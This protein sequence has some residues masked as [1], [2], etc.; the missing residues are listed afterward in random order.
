MKTSSII[1][2]SLCMFRLVPLLAAALAVPQGLQASTEYA[3]GSFTWDNG[4][5]AKWSNLPSGPY[6]TVWTSG[7][8]AVLEGTAGTVTVSSATTHSLTFNTT[9]YILSGASTLTLNGTTP[10]I[11]MPSGIAAATIG[12]NTATVLAGSAGLTKAGYG[13]V[14]LNSSAVHTFTG[15]LTINGGGG[16]GN[17][18]GGINVSL[19]NLATPTNLINSS[20]ALTLSGATLTLTGKGSAVSSQ[21]F[22][23]TTVNSG[24]AWVT[25]TQNSATSLTANLGAITRN[26]GGTLRFNNA[27]STTG[28]IATTTNSNESSGILGTWAAV[29]QNTTS[30]QYAA[31]NGS[32][33]IVTYT[34]ATTTAQ[35]ANLSDVSNSGVN[36]AF[37][38]TVTPTL[39]GPITAN[40]L[41]FTGATAGTVTTAGNNITLNGLMCAGSTTLTIGV[42]GGPNGNLVI[43]GNKE[44]VILDNNQALNIY[45]PITDNGGGASSLVFGTGGNGGSA[46]LYGNLNYTGA[47]TVNSGTL[48]L[49]P[50]ASSWTYTTENMTVNGGTLYLRGD[51]FAGGGNF[52]VGNITLNAGGVL[53]G[54]RANMVANTGCTLT[55]NGGRYFED[56]GFAGSWTGPVYLA[57][58]SYL[59]TNG[60]WCQNQAITGVISG[61]GG[62][63]SYSGNYNAVITLNSV[64]IYTGKTIITAGSSNTSGALQLGASGSIDT[65]PLISI[66]AGGIFDVSLKSAGYTWSSN[67]TLVAAGT[68]SPSSIKGASGKTINM[69]SQPI[70]LTYDG[71]HPA[72]TVSQGTLALNAN[73]ITVNGA[74]LLATSTYNVVSQTTG[75]ISV[76]GT[77][78][79]VGGSAIPTG[80]VGYLTT[81]GTSPGY[82]VLNLGTPSLT[83]SSFPSSQTAGVAGTVTVTAKDPLGNPATA[84]IGTVHFTSSDSLAVLPADYTFVPADN[85]THTFNVTLKTAG[86]QSITATDTGT[87]SITSTQSGITVTPAAAA[88]LTVAGFPA[89]KTAG[90]PD[91]V[92]VTAKDAF[93]NT[94]TG[95]TGT[96]HLS[97]S[98]GAASLPSDYTF[99]GGDSGTSVFS[100]TLNT[101][102]PP[103]VSITATDTVTGSITGTQSGITVLPGASAAYLVVSGF[104]ASPTAGVPGSITV[105][106]KSSGGT[107]VTSY[108]GTVHFTSTDGTATLPADYTFVSGDNGT[109]A[110]TGVILKTAAVQSITATDTGTAITGT[111]SSIGVVPD[112]AFSL[113][114]SGYPSP[115]FVGTAGDVTVTAKDA[116]GNVATAYNGTVQ[117]TSSDI[118]ATL[119]PNYSFTGAGGDNGTH[120]FTGGVTFA[121]AGTQ[122]IIATDTIIGS[123]TGTQSG[124]TVNLVP[125]L[126]SWTNASGG[127]W[128]V[129]GNWTNDAGLLLAPVAGGKSNYALSF[130]QAGSYTA[131]NNLGGNYLLNQLTF[132]GSGVTLAG[133]SLKLVSDTGLPAINQNS[134]TAVSIGNDL[135]LDADTTL[136]G[137]GAG[138]VTLTGVVSGTGSLTKN[139]TG[140]L[141]LTGLVANTYQG[142]TFINNGSVSFGNTLNGMLGTGT[143]TM[144][145]GT[146]LQFNG[147]NNVTN[148]FILRGATIINSNGFAANLNGPVALSGTCTA[149][150]GNTGQMVISGIVSDVSGTEIGSLTKIGASP[151]SLVLTAANTYTGTTTINAGQLQ[152]GS[153]GTTGSLAPSG[154]ITNNATLVF[155]RSNTMT[156]G[157]DFPTGISGSGALIQSGTGTLVLSGSNTYSGT[158]NVNSGTLLVNG[159]N[160][161]T[162]AVSVAS[163][164]TLGGSGSIGGNVTYAS[165]ALACFTQGSTLTIG[166]SLTLNDNIVHLVLPA[167]LAGGTY[168]LATYNATGSSGSFN[169]TPVIDSGSVVTG[170]TATVTTGAGFVKLVVM[171]S[172][173]FDTWAGGAAFDADTNG[174]GVSNGLAWLLGAANKDANAAGLLPTENESAGD[175]VLTFDCLAAS[176]RG[177]AVLNLQYS[178]DLGVSDPWSSHEVAVPGEVG[179]STVGGVNFTVTANGSLMHVVAVI[180]ASAASPG[181]VLFGR[182][183][184]IQP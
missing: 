43:G 70:V 96:V 29:G 147:T 154:T 37:G 74:T 30:V 49:S 146:S 127:T 97:S 126:F 1:L 182:L 64:N 170:A 87:G 56:N 113:V 151:G 52:T 36:Y 20:N 5:T 14:T 131:T 114:V 35:P 102:S 165:G 65:T 159:T 32:N 112:G 93:G 148:A 98:D 160:S 129:A 48:T 91:N 42:S 54:E 15:G 119:P 46:T 76:T 68:A 128:A 44:L 66:T 81:T 3:A 41:R 94:A 166:G 106:A 163:A 110:F 61:P 26:A 123:V 57:A 99:T 39:T 58:D 53:E 27:P 100:V 107:T 184:G 83:V 169:A 12:N 9:A 34:G 45:C 2:R 173:L 71:S 59:G 171:G 25:L 138:Q 104:P 103:T 19:A 109:H 18:S 75:A 88:S 164:A 121:T 156:Q 150:L 28:I 174:D 31:V 7:N 50:P 179:T 183:H 21:S 40:T 51:V 143:V 92:T 67:T 145:S 124:I 122:N 139:T 161:G 175:L 6:N 135:N 105:T 63:T 55:L 11:A 85:G 149:D 157:V 134:A 86:T 111:Q 80:K 84:Y 101:V 116:Y 79:G 4:S 108:T 23:S 95:Y 172:S 115:Q 78:P 77:L 13:T 144:A 90:T 176:D 118:S 10:S 22:A 60:G 141:T 38:A 120:T 132:G 82:L 162:G 133:N 8:D 117:F 140:N 142:G 47:T 130:S 69:G 125:H 62:L 180:P 177:T 168:T 24:G 89:A 181:T 17:S 136:G 178:R 137:S 16:A 167:N 153:G 73:P 158:T 155:K 72:L 152:L 33:Q